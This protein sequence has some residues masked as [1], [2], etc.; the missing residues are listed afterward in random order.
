LTQTRY[1]EV[2]GMD[3]ES[4]YYTCAHS[5]RCRYKWSWAED[6]KYQ[7]VILVQNVLSFLNLIHVGLKQ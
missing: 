1:Q 6:I 2:F 7:T 4:N 5:W 3:T